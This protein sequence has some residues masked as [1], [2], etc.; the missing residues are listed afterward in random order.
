MGGE[1]GGS[2]RRG[3]RRN[4]NWYAKN[5]LINFLKS[6][7]KYFF[8]NKFLTSAPCFLFPL[9]YSLERSLLD[10]EASCLGCWTNSLLVFFKQAF[11]GALLLKITPMV[12]KNNSLKNCKQIIFYKLYHFNCISYYC[13]LRSMY[14]KGF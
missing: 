9:S 8:C 5:K 1:E 11:C 10:I 7:V 3:L 13:Q 4:C 2:G 6:T 14:C 12:H